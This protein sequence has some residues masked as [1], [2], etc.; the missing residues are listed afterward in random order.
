M[1]IGAPTITASSIVIPITSGNLNV[2]DASALTLSLYIYLKSSGLTDNVILEFK[3]DATASSHGF[4]ADATGSTF[5]ATFASAPVSNQ[6]YIEVVA[7]KLNFVQQSSST[8]VNAIM[9]P[10]VTIEATDANNNRDLDV[11]GSVS[12]TSSGTMTGPVTATLASGF[13]TAGNIVH[14]SSGTSLNL[15]ASFWF[16]DECRQQSIFYYSFACCR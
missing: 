1:T 4:I 11:A 5:L 6:M 15:T 9:T 10:A 8:L 16:A 7:T 3:V 14:T 2:P 13:G 12:I